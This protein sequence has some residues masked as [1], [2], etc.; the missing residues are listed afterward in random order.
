MKSQLYYRLCTLQFCDKF[1][2]S[3]VAIA[4]I[5]YLMFLIFPNQFEYT[6]KIPHHP[7]YNKLME[8]IKQLN[9]NND[10]EDL[11]WCCNISSEYNIIPEKSWGT[12][13]ESNPLR[14]EWGKA[15][16]DIITGG[17]GRSNCKNNFVE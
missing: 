14:T 3:L 16:C 15:L 6:W 9:D 10:K 7:D 2:M 4:L 13:D 5:F 8:R 1:C 12:L 11:N 17:S